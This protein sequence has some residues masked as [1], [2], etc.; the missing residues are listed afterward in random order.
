MRCPGDA[1]PEIA[2]CSGRVADC[3]VCHT[4]TDPYSPDGALGPGWNAFGARFFVTGGKHEACCGP[5]ATAD[6]CHGTTT[7]GTAE[8]DVS[9]ECYAELFE[10]ELRERLEALA[11][12]PAA[13]ADGDCVSDRAELLAGT[14][15]SDAADHPWVPFQPP[16][17]VGEP[18][19]W[20][21][22][23][24]WDPAFALRRVRANYCGRSPA[25]QEME[26]LSAADDPQA[27][28]HD[29]LDE[30]LDSVFW[31]VRG[32]PRMGDALIRPAR[33]VSTDA[34]SGSGFPPLG[35]YNYDFR[36]FVWAMTA[37]RDA[38][39]LLLADYH[40]IDGQEF[41]TL[42]DSMA[43]VEGAIDAGS[44]GSQGSQPVP[45]PYRAGLLTTQWFMAINTQYA[46]LPRS[47]AAHAYKAYLGMDLARTEGIVPVAGEPL[48]VDF[49]DTQREPCS[50][51][52]GTLDP[53]AYA[54]AEYEGIQPA[55]VA[56]NGGYDPSLV[57]D[58][59]AWAD[60]N[61][62][63]H[64]LGVPIPWPGPETSA[65]VLWAE[66]A[67]NSDAFKRTLALSVFRQALDR[68]PAPDELAEF[69]AWWSAWGDDQG[70]SANQLIHALVDTD[71]F[72]AP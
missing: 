5:G 71:A 24:S 56:L 62:V 8:D 4:G 1:W 21:D 16:T 2:Q 51:C 18:N 26:A 64:L 36:L 38:R 40:L 29:A 49:K 69:T 52:H 47:T 46:E 28:V 39:D 67:A 27:A 32:V 20:Y 48:D 68:D 57:D 25:W 44:W 3:S 13:D 55:A 45:P 59:P 66:L 30:C 9:W 63:P 7:G 72:G 65:L 19:P 37:D 31:Y 61:P 58:M 54:F 17:P 42:A 15:P 12:D 23:G 60:A 53:L 33:M 10:D 34:D 35:D 41:T 70:W 11:D 14:S 50:F 6:T 43:V 22:V